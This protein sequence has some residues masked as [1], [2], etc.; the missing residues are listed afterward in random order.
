MM[1]PMQSG[2]KR[3]FNN[4][5]SSGASEGQEAEKRAKT[6]GD[7]LAALMQ[8]GS[9]EEE[10]GP[11]AAGEE[12]G[13][14]GEGQAAQARA[15]GANVPQTAEEKQALYAKHKDQ[16]SQSFSAW[17]GLYTLTCVTA[18]HAYLR[19]TCLEHLA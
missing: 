5:M 11:G 13:A 9:D 14:E 19:H 1:P 8:Y 17:S 2:T 16:A 15:N 7:G 6:E 10:D 12:P 18:L 4:A 3:P